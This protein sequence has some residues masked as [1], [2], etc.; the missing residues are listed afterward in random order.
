[1]ADR[2]EGVYGVCTTCNEL[3]MEV[4][5]FTHPCPRYIA[6]YSWARITNPT[7]EP[8]RPGYCFTVQQD[9]QKVGRHNVHRNTRVYTIQYEI[10]ADG[11]AVPRR[12]T[13]TRPTPDTQARVDTMIEQKL[14]KLFLTKEQLEHIVEVWGQANDPVSAEIA[15]SAKEKLAR[16]ADQA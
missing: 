4:D 2:P 9:S 15:Q 14:P 12:S 10:N 11:M 7:N 5:M 16:M 13:A 6:D 8:W 3:V 1:M